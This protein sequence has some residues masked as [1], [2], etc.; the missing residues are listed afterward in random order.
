ML[1]LRCDSRYLAPRPHHKREILEATRE[2]AALR[3]EVLNT[4][5]PIMRTRHLQGFR[6]IG[7]AKSPLQYVLTAA[8]MNPVRLSGW[9]TD[10]H[11]ARTRQSTLTALMTRPTVHEPLAS[12]IQTEAGP[13]HHRHRLAGTAGHIMI[14]HG[15]S[16]TQ[17]IA[18]TEAPR[19]ECGPSL[20]V[21]QSPQC[22]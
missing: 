12:S 22:F 13:Q 1:R 14:H 11:L 16:V 5:S 6:S 8:A 17:R 15:R 9:L 4:I 10:T 20:M 18:S 21:H 19:D 2:P 3:A 7:P